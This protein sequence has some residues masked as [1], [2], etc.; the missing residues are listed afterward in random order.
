MPNNAALKPARKNGT[1]V[2]L[3]AARFNM[4]SKVRNIVIDNEKFVWSVTEIDWNY[5]CIKV[6]A[7]GVKAQPWFQVKKRFDD[8]LG[9]FTPVTPKLVAWLITKI[10]K[11]YGVLKQPFITMSFEIDDDG[12]LLKT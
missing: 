6:W 3:N 4:K 1:A 2:A 10:L 12:N 11:S 5:V 9:N 8:P 7:K